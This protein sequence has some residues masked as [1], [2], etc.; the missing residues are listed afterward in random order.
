MHRLDPHLAERLTQNALSHCEELAYV[1]EME[2]GILRQYLTPHQKAGHELAA[3]WMR[4]CGMETWEDAVGN[5]WGRLASK[6]PNAKR[7]IFGSHLDTVPNAGK[8]DGI[9]GVMIAIELARAVHEQGIELPFHLDVVGFCDE[10]GTRFGATLIGSHA[11]AGNF[12]KNW[13]HVRDKN[14]ITMQQAMLDYGL[15]PDRVDE[16]AIAK[17]ELVEYWEVHIE[18]GPVLE[19]LEEP[20]G[21]VTGIAGA[22]RATVTISGQAGHAGT[23]P[24]SLRS[25]ALAAASEFVLAVEQLAQAGE[26]GEVATVGKL[27]VSPSATNVIPGNVELSL[28]IRALEDSKRDA[29]IEKILDRGRQMTEQRNVRINLEWTH[30]A[31]AV[32]CSET[33][34]ALFK[35]AGEFNGYK[36]PRLPSGAGHDAMAIAPLCDVGMLFILSPNGLSHHPEEAVFANDLKPAIE[37]LYS[38]L[39]AK[40]A[41]AC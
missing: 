20:I 19:S 1:S 31:P 30:E 18:Q 36:S 33:I 38:A 8:Y 9:L 3:K 39:L 24:M 40:A 26:H 37:T 32:K 4:D 10:E 29:L 7:L 11:L 28:D 16:A 35:E 13:L 25:D 34:Q 17:E 2:R 27:E 21:V 6:N 41:R 12:E 15:H 23:T 14:G 22:K 5:Q